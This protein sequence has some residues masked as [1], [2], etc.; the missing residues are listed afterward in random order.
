MQH[1]EQ[2]PAIVS[3]VDAPQ[4]TRG[5]YATYCKQRANRAY[6]HRSKQDLRR[7]INDDVEGFDGTPNASREHAT[8]WDLW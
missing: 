8:S 6:R 4:W 1:G 7:A 3:F 2:Q 5:A